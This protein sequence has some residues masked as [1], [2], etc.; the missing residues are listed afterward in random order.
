MSLSAS[1]R[2]ALVEAAAREGVD[3]SALLAAAEAL[4]GDG[5]VKPAESA[6]EV[7][8]ESKGVPSSQQG[9]PAADRLLI[10]FLP[11]IRV[12][13]LRSVWLGLDERLKDDEMTC[14]AFQLKYVGGGSPAVDNETV[15]AESGVA[16]EGE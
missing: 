8:V 7:S 4:V 9:H 10:G 2:Q 15:E 6:G 12:R 5:A 14:G 11:Y 13:E 16:A 3:S 1:Q